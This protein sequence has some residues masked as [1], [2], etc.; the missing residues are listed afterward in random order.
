MF[1]DIFE[2][3]CSPSRGELECELKDPEEFKLGLY[4]GICSDID[5]GRL[6]G[7]WEK[8]AEVGENASCAERLEPDRGV[9][10]A[11]GAGTY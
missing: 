11:V 1:I 10:D 6:L 7:S 8:L 3:D 2:K 5:S 4:S 9:G